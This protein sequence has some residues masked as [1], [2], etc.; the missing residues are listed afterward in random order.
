MRMK[1]YGSMLWVLGLVCVLTGGCSARGEISRLSENGE[2]DT[3]GTEEMDLQQENDPEQDHEQDGLVGVDYYNVN[4][5]LYG[6]DLSMDIRKDRVVSA[7]YFSRGEDD[8]ENPE[9]E[10]FEDYRTVENQPVSPEQWK[11]LEDAVRTIEPLLVEVKPRQNS[12]ADRMPEIGATDGPNI[13]TFYLTFM[14]DDGEEYRKQYRIP[15]DRRFG[16]VLQIMEEIV[17]P[18]GAEI[19]YYE[20]PVIDGIFFGQQGLW[21]TKRNR[22]SY[23]FNRDAHEENRWIYHAYYMGENGEEHVGLTLT[24]EYWEPVG[25][26]L[27]SVDFSTFPAGSSFKSKRYAT[28]YYSDGKQMTVQPDARTMN[29][30]R[31]YFEELNGRLLEQADGE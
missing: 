31:E 3:M 28:L 7:R 2:R 6:A 12:L 8:P 16:T 9:E 18:T 24:K 30:L 21:G 20:A 22:F 19:V 11:Q 15:N 10:Y 1:R 23:Q 27:Q 14:G 13:R 4:G 26:M 17:H 29:Q 5:M 25:E